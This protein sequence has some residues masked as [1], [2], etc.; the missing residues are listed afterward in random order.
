LDRFLIFC[1]VEHTWGLPHVY[2]QINWSNKQFQQVVNTGQSFNNCRL[3]WLEQREFFDIYLETVRDHPLYNIIQDE[4]HRAFNNV[5]RPN[6]DHFKTVSPTETF[7]LFP[8]S[9]NPIQVSFDKS[10]G[11]ISKLSRSD[12]IYWT[13]EHSQLASYVYITY[14]ETDFDQLTKTYGNP[15]MK[16]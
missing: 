10:L 6:L 16:K 4:L 11:S 1:F 14:N 12:S 8:N 2:D 5:A 3:A 7:I 13:D 15:G 9:S